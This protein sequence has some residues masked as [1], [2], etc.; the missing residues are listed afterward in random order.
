VPRAIIHVPEVQ[1]LDYTQAKSSYHLRSITVARAGSYE[2]KRDAPCIAS[3]LGGRSPR[4][5]INLQPV[6][7]I[8]T[9]NLKNQDPG[10]HTS[11]THS[12]SL[13][14][15]KSFDLTMT[16]HQKYIDDADESSVKTVLTTESETTTSTAAKHKLRFS[17][18]S[19]QVFPIVHISDMNLNDLRKTWYTTG[20]FGNIKQDMISDIRKML[21]GE[22]FAESNAQ[23]ARGLVYRTHQVNLRRKQNKSM[24]RKAV[25]DEQQRQLLKGERDDEHVANAYLRVSIYCRDEAYKLGFADQ[26]SIKKELEEMRRT[27]RIRNTD[28]CKMNLRC[29]NGLLMQASQPSFQRI[30]I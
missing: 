7:G 4:F 22:E 18:E 27:Y 15:T 24:A 3:G 1:L 10:L 2:R 5:F 21:S 11:L 12:K 13:L 8:P 29:P 25:L 26:E 17:L 30:T 6:P 14:E 20:E 16:E 23:T 28:D 9:Q 19:N